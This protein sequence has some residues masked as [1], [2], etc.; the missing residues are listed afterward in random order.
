[1]QGIRIGT[2][3]EFQGQEAEVAILME[4]QHMARLL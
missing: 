3:D 1:M 2:V 4:V